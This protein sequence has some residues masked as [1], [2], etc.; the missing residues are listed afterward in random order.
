MVSLDRF[1]SVGTELDFGLLRAFL[2]WS[3]LETEAERYP[4]RLR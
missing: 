3:C 2:G 4:G 1:D